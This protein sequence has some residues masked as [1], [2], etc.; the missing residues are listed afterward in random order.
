MLQPGH[1]RGLA[2]EGSAAQTLPLP[3]PGPGRLEGVRCRRRV[4]YCVVEAAGEDHEGEGRPR[5]ETGGGEDLGTDGVS[6]GTSDSRARRRGWGLGW[7]ARFGTG[8][9]TASEAF[10]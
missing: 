9:G 1:G 3:V 2:E 4:P 5:S 10:F 6:T 7:S 8:G